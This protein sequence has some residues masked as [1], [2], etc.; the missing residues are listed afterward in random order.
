MIISI[1]LDVLTVQYS[2]SVMIKG[3]VF[4]EGE[5]HRLPS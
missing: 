2:V 4:A 5:V 1:T 3:A